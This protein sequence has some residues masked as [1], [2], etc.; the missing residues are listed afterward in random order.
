MSYRYY[1]TND[2]LFMSFEV[3]IFKITVLSRREKFPGLF[4]R[5]I[6]IQREGDELSR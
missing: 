6:S 4:I 2:E 3:G 5:K 1:D